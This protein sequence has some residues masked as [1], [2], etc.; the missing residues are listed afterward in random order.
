MTASGD[1]SISAFYTMNFSLCDYSLLI[2]EM[3]K[4]KNRENRVLHIHLDAESSVISGLLSHGHQHTTGC[5]VRGKGTSVAREE[6]KYLYCPFPSNPLA[7]E[8]V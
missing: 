4:S 1:L 6:K 2:V 3:A 5:R 8:K 7:K